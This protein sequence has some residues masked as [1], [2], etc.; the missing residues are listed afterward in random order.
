MIAVFKREFLVVVVGRLAT[1]LIAIASLRIMTTILDPGAYGLWVLLMAFQAF[2][3]LAL[4]NPVDQHV[5][6]RTHEWW[7]N[8]CLLGHLGAYEKYLRV[9]SVFVTLAVIIWWNYTQDDGVT[10]LKYG[11]LAGLAVGLLVY[12]GTWSIVLPFTL[13]MLGFRTQSVLWTVLGALIALGTSAYLVN[14]AP[15]AV[16]WI[17]G[18]VVGASIGAFGAWR[19]LRKNSIESRVKWAVLPFSDF[20]STSTMKNF[21]LPLAAATGFM[22]LQSTGYRFWAGEVWGVSGL[23]IMVVGLGVSTQL[24]AIVEGLAMQFLY[25]YFA[26]RVAQANSPQQT[27]MAASDLLNVLAPLY[28]IWA[29]FNVL[30]AVTLLELLTDSRYH[31]SAPFV[32]FGA[33]IEFMRCITNLFSNTARATHQ[34]RGLILPYWLGALVVWSGLLLAHFK[35]ASLIDFGF[36]LI[37]AG[38]ATCASMIFKMQRIMR[39]SVNIPRMG[40]ALATIVVCFIVAIGFPVRVSGLLHNFLL[41][42]V[43]GTGAVCIIMLSLWNNPALL[44][45]LAANLNGNYQ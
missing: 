4:I 18:Q 26:R 9:V 23:G 34:T 14:H 30:C 15:H 12:T 31:L 2:C 27:A 11:L 39:L 10:Y 41:L 28:A 1:A 24:T 20:L 19:S 6:R 13:N 40:L 36:I 38:F 5:F 21:C 44:R 17:F 3:G 8:G 7:D 43:V 45:L 25:P 22:W 16:W 33:S 29:G 35:E 37:F 42:V 32:L